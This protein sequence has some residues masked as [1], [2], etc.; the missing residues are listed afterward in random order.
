MLYCIYYVL[1][2]RRSINV[3]RVSKHVTVEV[4]TETHYDRDWSDESGCKLC[5]KLR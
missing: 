3:V 5:Q 1:C 4:L 2:M